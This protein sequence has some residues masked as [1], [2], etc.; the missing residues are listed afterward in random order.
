MDG[1]AF[2]TCVIRQILEIIHTVL[3][4]ILQCITMWPIKLIK[5]GDK[6][7]SH[8]VTLR[9]NNEEYCKLKQAVKRT[10]LPQSEFIRNALVN[11]VHAVM[12]VKSIK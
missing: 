9:L 6:Q 1:L 11:R 2:F 5:V 12:Q 3:F 8:V 10:K 7:M 4:S